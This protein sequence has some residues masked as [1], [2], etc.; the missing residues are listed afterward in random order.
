M[1][2]SFGTSF[3]SKNCDSKGNLGIR[4][5]IKFCNKPLLRCLM[6]RQKDVYLYMYFDF[7]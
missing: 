1:F 4:L 6:D 7:D 2:P 5:N 3:I